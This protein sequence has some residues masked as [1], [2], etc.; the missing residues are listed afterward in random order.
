M[1]KQLLFF[2]FMLL[3]MAASADKSGSIGESVSWVYIDGTKTL[4][5]SGTG[6]LYVSIMIEEIPWA[7]FR[8]EIENV[9]I[10]NGIP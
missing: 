2:L 8:D 1:K 4:T 9:I 5:I 10:E 3:P 7:N 6:G